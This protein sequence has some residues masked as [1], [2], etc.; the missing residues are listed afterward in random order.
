MHGSKF[1]C[2]FS[3]E[4]KILFGNHFVPSSVLSDV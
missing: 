3:L 1:P 4:D 2:D